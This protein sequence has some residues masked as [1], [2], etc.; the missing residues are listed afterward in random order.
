M[1][2]TND[3]ADRTPSSVLL[4]EDSRTT[5]ALLAKHLAAHYH[6]LEAH[7]G[8]EAWALLQGEANIGLVITDVNMPR[9]TGQELLAKIRKS[10]DPRIRSLPVIVMT[11][12][13][14]ATDRNL[15]FLN[16]AND[17][18]NKPVDALELQA[19][20]N[21][22]YTLARTIRELEESQRQLAALAAT[23]P[24][25]GLKNRRAFFERCRE[26]LIAAARLRSDVSVLVVDVDHFKRINDQYGH[27]AGDAVLV[28]LARLLEGALRGDDTVARLGGEEF[29]VLLPTTNRLAAA[30]I[31]ERM[32]KAAQEE[33]FEVGGQPV[34][35]TVSIGVAS[36]SA[37]T[38]NTIEELL[39]IADKRVYLAK[40]LG[41]NRICVTDDGRTTFSG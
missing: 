5:Q 27:P 2:A 11:A 20:V 35:L 28:R 16:G 23:D 34:S 29:A 22:H 13:E 18:I 1:P 36:F 30:V 24:L 3:S 32:R 4:V 12:A 37:E 14:D 38:V 26:A 33:R 40:N 31:A 9:M 7:D 25:T 15:A 8:E 6:T 39:A 19:R 17:Y 41:R 10:D 21:V